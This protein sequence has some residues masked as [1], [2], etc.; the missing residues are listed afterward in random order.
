MREVG[1]Q[2]FLELEANSHRE[3]TQ[4]LRGHALLKP[5]DE[6]GRQ[7]GG[8]VGKSWIIRHTLYKFELAWSL[9]GIGLKL[10]L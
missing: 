6:G 8:D 3:G 2:A 10:P 7:A 4:F 1:R 5:L 9:H